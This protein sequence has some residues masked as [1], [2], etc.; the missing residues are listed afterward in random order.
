MNPIPIISALILLFSFS[1]SYQAPSGC[2]PAE[3]LPENSTTL[4]SFGERAEWSLDGRK[5]FFIDS[6]AGDAW[7]VD[8]KSKRLKKI[9]QP[10]FRP[11]GHGYYRVM[12]LANG[13][14]LLNCGPDRYKTYMQIMD[15]SLSKPPQTL[16]EDIN[17][18]AAVSRKDMK[19]AW[20]ERQNTIWT[21]NIVYKDGIPEIAD[22]KLVISNDS[23]IVDGIK[24]TGMIEPQNFR[25]PGEIELIWSQYGTSEKGIFTSEVFGYNLET[26]D[27]VN[28]SKAPNQYDEPEGIFPDGDYTLVEC[29]RHNPLGTSV[30]DIYKLKLDGTGKDYTRLTFFSEIKGYRSSNPVVSDDGK[31]MAFQ[32]SKSGTA[33]GYGCG[34]YLMKL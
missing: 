32:A 4:T 28:Y 12:C 33:P 17:E 8:V 2:F 6:A 34:I 27:I 11:E 1:C 9:T 26:G 30:I 19:I 14:L 5:I 10:G 7:Q 13:D 18:G 31:Y 3:K 22:R 29:D 21:G 23:V 24:Y 15:K 20:T 16:Q 25:P